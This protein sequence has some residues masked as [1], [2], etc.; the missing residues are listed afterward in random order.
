M[1]EIVQPPQIPTE[2]TKDEGRSPSHSRCTTDALS[3]PAMPSSSEFVGE[4]WSALSQGAYFNPFDFSDAVNAMDLRANELL[5]L[6]NSFS[7]ALGRARDEV[8][9][10]LERNYKDIVSILQYSITHFNDRKPPR[11]QVGEPG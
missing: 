11:S 10:V 1:R 6:H 9:P 7:E 8:K 2:K 5:F 4:V 3:R